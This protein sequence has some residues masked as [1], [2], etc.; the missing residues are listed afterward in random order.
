ML[1][2]LLKIMLLGLI[3][4][5]GCK[6]PVEQDD[7]LK[8]VKIGD[9]AAKDY[10]EPA[11]QK[12]KTM[13]FTVFTY[14][15]SLKNLEKTEK[16]WELLYSK[17][18]KYN[19]PESFGSNYFAAGYGQF[20]SWEKAAEFLYS[21]GG[22][23]IN[24]DY[25][26]ITDTSAGEFTAAM[27]NQAK[28]FWYYNAQNR[29][30]GLSL[31]PG[32]LMLKVN[33]T[34]SAEFKGTAYIQM[35]PAYI[36]ARRNFSPIEFKSVGLNIVMSPGDFIVLGPTKYTSGDFTLGGLFFNSPNKKGFVRFYQIVCVRV[37]N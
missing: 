5:A 7:L 20:A 16:M 8:G 4:T 30:E 9:L 33:A 15:V 34:L 17:P 14:E 26:L 18:I 19:N 27:L 35:F 13:N 37:G 6:G 36:S 28:P 12:L 11:F 22:K 1:T 32:I 24:T 10:N 31:E 25:L 23:K 2:K 3:I 21:A 29:L